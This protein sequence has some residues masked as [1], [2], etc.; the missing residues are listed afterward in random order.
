MRLNHLN[1]NVKDVSKTKTFFESYFGFTCLH[2]RGKN[3]LAVM[4][5]DEGFALTIMSE[6]FNKKKDISYPENFHIGF[7][8]ETKKQ[9]INLYNKLR[10]GG[11]A[12]ENE[13]KEN[14][15][16]FGF[17]FHFSGFMIEVGC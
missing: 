13:P 16:G 10:H 2:E 11:I 8:V 17:Y 9:V 14:N 1:L 7:M 15:H 5:D 3:V 4:T 12:L 6:A